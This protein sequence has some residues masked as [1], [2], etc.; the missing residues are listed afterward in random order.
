[1][2]KT[3]GHGTVLTPLGAG[4]LDALGRTLGAFEPDLAE[5]GRALEARLT[6]LLDAGPTRLRLATSHDPLLLEAL[7]AL[8]HVDVRVVGSQ[9]AVSL[10]LAG[11]AD[12]AGFHVGADEAPTQP[13]PLASAVARGE[14]GTVP[15]FRREQGFVVAPGNP[16]AIENV[17]DI[18]RM[19]ARFVN[20]QRG[21]GTR[22]WFDGLLTRAGLEPARIEGYGTEEFTHAAVAALVAAGAAD[23][24]MALRWAAWRFDL[25]FVPVGWE[26]FD[27]AGRPEV[28]AQAAGAIRAALRER[29]AGTEG[30]A[31]AE[32]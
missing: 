17:A 19:R 21:S 24:G 5:E 31:A 12:L 29:V 28:L 2:V 18:A 9:E 23:V 20:R 10:L 25:G 14:I 1:V 13:G 8:P 4:L 3:K 27:L 11:E 30:Y 26:P 22:R 15:L 7:A 32:P 16:L 6:A